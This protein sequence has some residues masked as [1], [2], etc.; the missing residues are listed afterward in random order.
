M[1]INYFCS[2]ICRSIRIIEAAT[3]RSDPA[4]DQAS[5]S[6]S[7]YPEALAKKPLKR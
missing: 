3:G 2:M 1:H 5:T 7:V 4:D 6:E